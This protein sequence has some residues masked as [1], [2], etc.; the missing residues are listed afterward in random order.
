MWKNFPLEVLDYILC[1]ISK[2][3]MGVSVLKTTSLF[4]LRRKKNTPMH[5][6]N[7]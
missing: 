4:H 3:T 7:A 1:H 6:S 2:K 5:S